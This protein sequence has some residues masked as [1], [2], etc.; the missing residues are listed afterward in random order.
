MVAIEVSNRSGADVDEAAAID[1][2]HKVLAGIARRLREA[3]AQSV[4]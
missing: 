3:D 4:Q 1:L 2:A